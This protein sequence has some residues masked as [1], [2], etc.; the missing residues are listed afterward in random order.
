VT[1]VVACGQLREARNET[2]V[3]DGHG[4]VIC[5]LRIVRDFEVVQ[6]ALLGHGAREVQQIK[7]HSDIESGGLLPQPPPLLK[8]VAK[9]GERGRQARVGCSTVLHVC[10]RRPRGGAE[11]AL[12]LRRRV[13]R[14]QHQRGPSMATALRWSERRTDTHA[15]SPMC[16]DWFA[17]SIVKFLHASA[18]NS[19]PLPS[20]V[21]GAGAAAAWAT[22]KT[23]AERSATT[24]AVVEAVR[25]RAPIVVVVKT[26]GTLCALF[27]DSHARFTVLLQCTNSDF[28]ALMIIDTSSLSLNI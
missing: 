10:A 7:Q 3:L 18:T 27:T 17:R 13:V 14:D 11:D 12:Y 1:S 22:M 19:S 9:H 25:W 20:L 26:M 4:K 8:L 16:G 28:I 23:V 15:S 6:C 24:T 5:R 2:Y 21:P